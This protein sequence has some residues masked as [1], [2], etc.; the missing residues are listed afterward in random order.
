M[1]VENGRLSLL[2]AIEHHFHDLKNAHESMADADVV[3]AFPMSDAQLSSLMSVLE[4]KFGRKLNPT[5][6]IDPQLIGGVRVTVGDE[7][8]D[9]SVSARLEQMHTALVA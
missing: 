4:K 6:T 7:V 9:H 2:P 3:S 1:L 5:V 8:L